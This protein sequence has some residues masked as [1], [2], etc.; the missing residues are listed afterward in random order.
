[1][2]LILHIDTALASGSVGISE[3][4]RLLL[5]LQND[6][7]NNHAAFVQPAID[8]LLS[9]TA[10]SPH[11]LD[12]I[13]TVAGPG[14]YTGLRVGMATAKGLCY[15]L[16]KPLLAVNTLA[17][18]A[19]SAIA[20]LPGYELFCPMIDARRNEVFTAVYNRQAEALLAPQPMILN[21]ESF[22]QFRENPRIL[23]LGDG[24]EKA[25][26]I[27]NNIEGWRFM[28]YQY[29]VAD[30]GLAFFKSFI[31]RQFQDL[32]YTEPLYL[33]DFYMGPTK[34]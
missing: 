31:N 25:K 34:N 28:G 4:G 14:S 7:P 11:S 21:E 32:A 22:L 9:E 29:P 30:I 33:K 23:F 16:Q 17:L 27:L 19:E 12:A 13:G 6:I 10:I 15:A 1:M 20:Q 2:A 26:I 24:A 3:N 5:S 18:M 8:K